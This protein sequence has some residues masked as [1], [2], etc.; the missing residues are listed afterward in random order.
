ML[1]SY[2]SLPLVTN[3]IEISPLQLALF[4]EGSLDFLLEKRIR[5]MAWSPLA[6][7]QIFNQDQRRLRVAETLRA[8]GEKYGEQRLDVLSYAWLLARPAKIMLIIGSGQIARVE[9]AVRALDITFTEE[10]WINVYF[11]S[12]GYDIP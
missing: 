4:D 3:Q 6:G 12:Q 10:E 5:P 7:G 2:L 1:Q 8:I 9:S 11:A